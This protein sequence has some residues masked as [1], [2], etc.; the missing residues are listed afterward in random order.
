MQ[1]SLAS[2][3]AATVTFWMV[4]PNRGASLLPIPAWMSLLT[5]A[6]GERESVVVSEGGRVRGEIEV[7]A[8]CREKERESLVCG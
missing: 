3:P 4:S 8:G 1:E 5:L 6:V 7:R 2:R